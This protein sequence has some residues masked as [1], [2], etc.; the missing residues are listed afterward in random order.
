MIIQR[1]KARS[2]PPRGHQIFYV[3]ECWTFSI[4]RSAYFDRSCQYCL[5][6]VP[7]LNTFIIVCY[8]FNSSPD[9]QL[10][11]FWRVNQAVFF[12]NYMQTEFCIVNAFCYTENAKVETTKFQL[13]V[14]FFQ[15]NLFQIKLG[16]NVL[17]FGICCIL[18]KSHLNGSRSDLSK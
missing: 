5:H 6:S 18:L 7:I 17:C 12:S 15:E 13:Y 3:N 16:V 2:T 9:R 1:Y 8:H 4:Q 11:W 10:K 14:C